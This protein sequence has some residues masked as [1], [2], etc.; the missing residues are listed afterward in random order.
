VK[1][2]NK[3]N[4]AVK[5]IRELKG[6]SQEYMAS[7]LNISQSA[8]SNLESGKSKFTLD[9]AIQ[10]SI[11]LEVDLR[12]YLENIPHI[13]SI[14]NDIKL[15]ENEINSLN[16]NLY[17]ELVNQLIEEIKFLRSQLEKKLTT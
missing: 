11:V 14:P 10:I 7:M 3:F 8:Y 2:L 15:D 16:L 9:R 17:R 5:R 13:Q 6:Y 4:A 1:T 12:E